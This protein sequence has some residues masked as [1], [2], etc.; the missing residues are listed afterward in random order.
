MDLE[1]YDYD[2]SK[3]PLIRATEKTLLERIPPRVR[4]RKNAVLEMPHII[5][6]IDDEDDNVIGGLHMQRDALEK[7]YDFDLMMAA[8]V[9]GGLPR[10]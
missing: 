8:A 5:L 10:A 9:E 1:R 6:I 7:I 3:K 2:I 4:I